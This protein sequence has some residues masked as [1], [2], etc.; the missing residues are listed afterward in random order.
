[1]SNI[2]FYHFECPHCAG[3]ILVQQNELN[4]CIFRHG[5]YKHNNQQIHPHLPK[6]M[7]DRLVA[8]NAIY[9][10]GKPFQVVKDGSGN[11]Q[12]IIC[13]YI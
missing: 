11:Y 8:R 10:C 3:N 1:M 9:G 7:C 12:A 13:G 2:E 6:Q 5:V 4:C